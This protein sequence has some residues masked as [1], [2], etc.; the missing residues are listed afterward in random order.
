MTKITVQCSGKV[1]RGEG[2]VLGNL[3]I[4]DEKNID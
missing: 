1:V 2:M 4:P 3:A